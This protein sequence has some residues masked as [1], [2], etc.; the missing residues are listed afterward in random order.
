M[1]T[2]LPPANSAKKWLIIDADGQ[3]VGRLASRIAS[4]LRGKE[5]PAF[6]AHSD[7]G[8]FVVVVNAAKIKFTGQ[9]LQQKI[10]RLFTI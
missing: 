6:T 2:Y 10:L 9:K 1:K 4:I 5:N 8:D 7:T 3:V